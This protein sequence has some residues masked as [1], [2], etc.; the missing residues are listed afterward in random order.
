MEL[1]DLSRQLIRIAPSR[2]E[3]RMTKN[4]I[5]RR[6]LIATGA[7]LAVAAAS[8]SAAE[9]QVKSRLT[10]HV[11][12]TFSG[13]PGEGVTI[14]F[15]KRE[16]DAYVLQKT[17]VTNQDGR[18]GEPLLPVEGPASLGQYRLLF[19]VADY[20]RKIGAP[21]PDPPFIDRVSVDFA[22]Y[23]EKQHYHV[24]LLCSPW[25]YTTYRGS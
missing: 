21:L 1:F 9:A 17:V 5:G 24:P 14:E 19:H 23:E 2:R 6:G 10:T 25:S 8:G 20:F 4:G 15:Y 12:D 13:I 3:T 16:G 11:L 22:I 18:A 7:A